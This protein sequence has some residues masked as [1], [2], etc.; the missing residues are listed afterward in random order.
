MERR[1]HNSAREPGVLSRIRAHYSELSDAERAVSEVV[2]AAP[3]RVIGASLADLASWAGVSDATALRFARAI[4]FAGF[5]EMKFALVTDSVTP[6]EAVFEEI[7]PDDTVGEI[8]RKVVQ[9]NVQLL[10]D[11]LAVL[12]EGAV[13]EAV[14]SLAHASRIR[15][16]AVG[17]SAPVA[18]TAGSLLHRLAIEN[19][20][21]T[22]VYQQTVAA[23]L[24]R[25]GDLIVAISVSGATRMLVQAV[26]I[27]KSRGA[28]CLAITTD[29]RS[30][31]ARASDIVLIG[32][33]R[34]IRP[35][36]IA[37]TVTVATVVEALYVALAVRD[38]KQTVAN[39]RAIFDAMKAQS[40]ALARRDQKRRRPE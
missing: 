5:N 39:E 21:V 6:V 28:K 26:A 12:D 8:A 15:I 20:V 36:S 13:T 18:L 40:T 7:S 27:A 35:E 2:T 23:G 34:E 11:T 14:E 4:G 16:F 19:N 1:D 25:E 32:A 37:S 9:F 31:L 30:K 24:A 10:T 3:E 38:Q 22:D 29:K 33:G 17:R